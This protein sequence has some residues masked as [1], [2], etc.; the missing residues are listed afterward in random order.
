MR[1]HLRA[2]ATT[3]AFGLALS[4]ARST[5]GTWIATRLQPWGHDWN[6]E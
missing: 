2:A 5:H 3:L 4:N 1:R 6:D